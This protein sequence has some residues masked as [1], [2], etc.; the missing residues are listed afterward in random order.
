[1]Q[2]EN[3]A[4]SLRRTREPSVPFLCNVPQAVLLDEQG[5]GSGHGNGCSD[6]ICTD[7]IEVRG[8]ASYATLLEIE[9]AAAV[10]PRFRRSHGRDDAHT[11]AP[12]LAMSSRPLSRKVS[13]LPGRQL[14]VRW[15]STMAGGLA[16]TSL[17]C[18]SFLR[19]RQTLA[20][21]G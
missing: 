10:V 6:R 18:I 13:D 16:A 15:R 1:M 19:W 4:S 7:N 5:G 8:L 17:R 20:T 3:A 11:Y 2:Q 12:A 14:P 9:N 21:T